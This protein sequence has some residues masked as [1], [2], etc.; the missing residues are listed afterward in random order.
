MAQ[1]E[2]TEDA[3]SEISLKLSERSFNKLTSSTPISSETETEKTLQ[4]AEQEKM[5]IEYLL[6]LEK[7]QGEVEA[8]TD[9]FVVHE[10]SSK[11]DDFKLSSSKR[12]Q[13]AQL[14]L[15]QHKI[16]DFFQFIVA[17]LLSASPD[18][19]ITFIMELLNRCLLYRSRLGQPPIL[20]EKKHLDQL[21]NMMDRMRT[22][23]IAPDQYKKAITSL[24]IC[25][26]NEHPL[27]NNEGFVTKRIFTEEA[28]KAQ[29]IY[30]HE[31][32]KVRH[33]RNER[34]PSTISDLEASTLDSTG[35]YF[36]PSGL[37]KPIQKVANKN[38]EKKSD[39]VES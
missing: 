17:H 8:L 1:E 35:S 12:M 2:A 33:V 32:V 4:E 24:G 31:L 5:C 3:K 39:I 13:E 16:F 25:D 30:F 34:E 18:N 15:L 20:Y 9:E 19:P 37:F 27:T 21:F 26:F 36:M 14:Y 10:E 22:G 23:S 6:G 28:Y 7:L 38:T 11:A 29:V